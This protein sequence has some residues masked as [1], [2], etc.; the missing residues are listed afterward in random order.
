MLRIVS[1]ALPTVC[2]P[3]RTGTGGWGTRLPAR[4]RP[5]SCAARRD[6]PTQ[7]PARRSWTSG[8]R[9]RR[10]RHD[11]RERKQAPSVKPCRP[12]YDAHRDIRGD[13]FPHVLSRVAQRRPERSRGLDIPQVDLREDCRLDKVRGLAEA[14]APWSDRLRPSLEHDVQLGPNEVRVKDEQGVLDRTS[15]QD[16]V[17]ERFRRGRG[18]TDDREDVGALQSICLC[19]LWEEGVITDQESDPTELRLDEREAVSSAETQALLAGT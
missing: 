3:T 10:V 6:E 9:R 17:E 1:G 11:D 18:G 13:R 14:L 8:R 15:G 12:S 4:S 5:T 19:Q 2:I 16:P 7:R